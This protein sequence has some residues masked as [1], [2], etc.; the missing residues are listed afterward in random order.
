MENVIFSL[1]LFEIYFKYMFL[2]HVHA[3]VQ[4]MRIIAGY[5]SYPTRW[6]EQ[7]NPLLLLL[8][9]VNIGLSSIEKM[10]ETEEK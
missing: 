6:R 3:Y 9:S 5:R 8:F 2:I 10:N 4:S 1:A 7:S